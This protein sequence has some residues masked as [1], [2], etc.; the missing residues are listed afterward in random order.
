MC[1]AECWQDFALAGTA[2]C[3]SGDTEISGWVLPITFILLDGFLWKKKIIIK[4]PG[5]NETMTA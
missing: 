3:P 4:A 2:W 5:E 1:G